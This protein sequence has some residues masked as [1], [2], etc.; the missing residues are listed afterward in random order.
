M[1]SKKPHL[2]AMREQLAAGQAHLL[3]VREPNEW[4]TGHLADATLVPLSTLQGG[5]RPAALADVKAGAKI[6]L[7]CR[8]GRRV[9][10]AAP[11]LRQHGF[12]DV[13]PLDEGFDELASLGFAR[14]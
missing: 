7:H 10:T 5:Q 9:Q 8:S 3:D 4:Q 14:G 1:I 11:L 12:D 13:T 2:L 6:Y